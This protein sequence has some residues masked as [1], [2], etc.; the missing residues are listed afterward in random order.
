LHEELMVYQYGPD[1]YFT[2]HVFWVVEAKYEN[3]IMNLETKISETAL[4]IPN[5]K[6]Q[7][8]QIYEDYDI[9]QT[10]TTAPLTTGIPEFHLQQLC[11]KYELTQINTTSVLIDNEI[12]TAWQSQMLDDPTVDQPG[13]IDLILEAEEVGHI[14]QSSL[15]KIENMPVEE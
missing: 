8:K 11:D 10:N 3:A 14:L 9:S 7:L 12:F 15:Q 6:F 13:P 2:D 1:S 5:E 4:V